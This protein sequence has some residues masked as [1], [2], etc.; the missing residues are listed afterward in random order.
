MIISETFEIAWSSLWRNKLR[1]FLT[2]LGIII[3][4][5]SVILLMSI[6][7]GLQSYITQQFESLGSNMVYVMPGNMES[8]GS[9]SMRQILGY[10]EMQLIKRIGYPIRTV[11][12]NV[13]VQ[14]SIKYKTTEKT[15]EVNGFDGTSLRAMNYQSEK[16][17]LLT[18]EDVD[19]NSRVAL[20]GK[21]VQDKFFAGIDP[22]DKS[23]L[24]QSTAYKVVGVFKP[25]GGGGAGIAGASIDN[26]VL[27]PLSTAQKQ[28]NQDKFTMLIISVANKDEIKNA[29]EKIEKELLKRHEK[30]D[31]SVMGPEDLLNTINQILGVLTAGLGGIA[32]ISLLVGGIGIMNIMFV[33]V[34]ERTKEIGLRKALGAT[35]KDI[36]VQFVVEAVSVS[37]IGGTIGI[38]IAILGSLALS[39]FIS[40]QVTPMAVGLAFGFSSLIG[41]VFGVAPAAKAA[42]LD[43]ITALRYE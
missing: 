26:Q 5:A 40:S 21:E 20:I 22:I 9:M 31:F 1:L 24:V 25:K 33:S 17:R 4:V 7:S 14:A 11:G 43:P 19:K 13:S 27:I 28:F 16:G 42:K 34:T 36:L 38:L 30:D 39:Q 29:K 37:L 18:D 3:G 23:I 41:I 15:L 6:G 35:P 8:A 12:G 10:P 2:M 32:A